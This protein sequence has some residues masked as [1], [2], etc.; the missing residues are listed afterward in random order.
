MMIQQTIQIE[1]PPSKDAPQDFVFQNYQKYGL[2]ILLAG[3]LYFRLV[4][5]KRKNDRVCPRCDF[6]NQPHISNC[7]NCGAPLMD[8]GH[9]K[10]MRS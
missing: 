4:L 5:R 9:H 6:R 3:L 10:S 7:T 2:L 8:T 1:R